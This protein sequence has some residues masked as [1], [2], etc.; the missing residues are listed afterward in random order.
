MG[1]DKKIDGSVEEQKWY[2]GMRP[3]RDI[4]HLL[5]HDGDFL[6]RASDGRT[7][8]VEIILSV[9]SE[10]KGLMHLTLACVEGK[11]QLGLTKSGKKIQRFN[12]IPQL[13]EYYK[14]HKLSNSLILK[15]PVY[16]PDW[17]I[18]H[19]KVTF[20]RTKDHLG[21]GNFCD[22]FK[23]KYDKGDDQVIDVAVKVCH[24]QIEDGK[25]PEE[26]REAREMM[27]GEAKAMSHF[28]HNYIIQLYGVACD[29]PPVLIVMEYCPG[30]SLDK[31]LLEQKENIE[32]AERLV[33]VNEAARG[34]RYL[35]S[36]NCVHR[37]LAARNCLIS[38]QGFIKIS[39][40]GLSK[41]LD[42][43][44]EE[45]TIDESSP[46]I[47]L[48]WMAPESL[49]KP[50]KFSKASD[51][52]SFGVLL[53]EIYNDGEKPWPDW[54]PKKIATFIRKAS[55]PAMP[56]KTPPEVKELVAKMWN[57]NANERPTIREIVAKVW[58]ILR[59]STLPK[60]N[61]FSVNK[62]PGVERVVSLWESSI[63][64][65]NDE[66][67]DTTNKDSI[68]GASTNKFGSGEM[69]R[70]K[71][72]LVEGIMRPM[73]IKKRG[74]RGGL[75]VSGPSTTGVGSI[76]SKLDFS[77]ISSKGKSPVYSG[78]S[79]SASQNAIRPALEEKWK[80]FGETFNLNI[81][82]FMKSVNDSIEQEKFNKMERMIVCVL[83]YFLHIHPEKFKI[84]YRLIGVV[85]D[86]VKKYANR[87]KQNHVHRGFLYILCNSRHFPENILKLFVAITTSLAKQQQILD[88]CYIIAFLHDAIGTNSGL[89]TANRC[90]WIDKPY[91]Q[92]LVELIL[93]P[94]G[95]V[96][97]SNELYASCSL[98]VQEGLTPPEYFP[99]LKPSDN[100]ATDQLL[101]YVEYF[102]TWFENL[103]TEFLPK[104]LFRALSILCGS[105][106][107]RSFV[108]SRIE[109]WINSQKYNREVCEILLV[110][111]KNLDGA[112]D[113]D[114][115]ESLLKLTNKNMKARV[116]ANPLSVA[117]KCAYEK[118]EN[119]TIFV[120]LLLAT[121][122]GPVQNKNSSNL[123][124][125]YSILVAQPDEATAAIAKYCAE[126]LIKDKENTAAKIRSLIK[127]LTRGYMHL[128]GGFFRFS[129]FAKQFLDVISRESLKGIFEHLPMLACETVA[130]ATLASLVAV[131]S[132]NENAFAK[133]FNTTESTISPEAR[134][135]RERFQKEFRE[136][137]VIVLKWLSQGKV[138]FI[139][140]SAHEHAY[141]VLL[142]LG[143]LR[144][145]YTNIDASAVS[146]EGEFKNC[147]RIFGEC[148]ITEEMILLIIGDIDCPLSLPASM[149]VIT[150]LTERASKNWL[151]YSKEPLIRF[152][153]PMKLCMR[154]MEHSIINKKLR[155]LDSKEPV[156][157]NKTYF[158]MGF[159]LIM[160][161]IS[162]GEVPEE[163]E[164]IYEK[165]PMI[166]Y[167][168]QNVLLNTFQFPMPFDGKSQT[169]IY[170]E[171][172]EYNNAE[173]E[174]INGYFERL[175]NQGVFQM[176]G[177]S[178]VY[179]PFLLREP[180]IFGELANFARI[181]N[182][183]S[184][185]ALC[186]KPHLLSIYSEQYGV[187][188][189]IYAI[190]EMIAVNPMGISLVEDEC[191]YLTIEYYLTNGK[192]EEEAQKNTNLE[193]LFG[194]LTNIL[195]KQS[196]SGSD[197]DPVVNTI[198]NSLSSQSYATR[199]AAVTI[200]SRIFPINDG[201]V[202]FDVEQ[203]SKT[204]KFAGNRTHFMKMLALA[205][206][207]ENGP[208]L[209]R[210]YLTFLQDHLEPES[211]HE[212]AR[213]ICGVAFSNRYALRNEICEFFVKYI[214]A[215]PDIRQN[216]QSQ[217]NRTTLEIASQRISVEKD[218]PEAVIH[219]L[220]TYPEQEGADDQYVRSLMEVWLT[221]GSIP[222]R[223]DE[224]TGA[225]EPILNMT[226]RKTMLTSTQKPVVDA[227]L[228]GLTEKDASDFV[229]VS[230]MTIN[231]AEA[232][233]Q[234]ADNMNVDGFDLATLSNMYILLTGY[235][236]KGVKAGTKLLENVKNCLDRL[237][238]SNIV[239]EEEPMVVEEFP[240]DDQPAPFIRADEKSLLLT[241]APPK[242]T[243]QEIASWL[244]TNCAG[245]AQKNRPPPASK[246][247][248]GFIQSVV[249]NSG[250]ATTCLKHIE[251][252]LKFFLANENLFQMLMVVVDAASQRCSDLQNRLE[253][254]AIRVL[255]SVN[256][257]ASVKAVLEKHA[258][259]GIM[260]QKKAASAAKPMISNIGQLANSIRK[261]KDVNERRLLL[262]DF[263]SNVMHEKNEEPKSEDVAIF[264]Q[265]LWDVNSEG[266]DGSDE[267][268][269]H[270]CVSSNWTIHLKRN[271]CVSLLNHY[272]SSL[273][274]LL[275]F[276][277]IESYCRTFPIA[278]YRELFTLK[279]K[280]EKIEFVLNTAAFTSIA[281]YFANIASQSEEFDLNIVS[282]FENMER[283]GGVHASLCLGEQL[284]ATRCANDSKEIRCAAQRII[285]L[286]LDRFPYLTYERG[287][288][289][290]MRILS[291]V[292]T[293]ENCIRK[294]EQI[295]DRIIEAPVENQ[296]IEDI[297]EDDRIATASSSKENDIQNAMIG[298][299]RYGDNRRGPPTK[300]GKW[301]KDES[302]DNGETAAAATKN[303]E[304]ITAI[305]QFNAMLREHPNIVKTKFPIL[306]NFVSNICAMN[307]SD[308]K[309]E[310]RVRK[311]ELVLSAVVTLC[312]YLRDDEFSSVDTALTN[313][314]EF[315]EKHIEE[316]LLHIRDQIAFSELLIKACA[317]YLNR[318]T[319]DARILLRDNKP[320][321]DRICKRCR[322][323]DVDLILDNLVAETV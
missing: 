287:I 24:A 44:K 211:M 76:K 135:V 190:K 176:P 254:L 241:A 84:E 42:G 15:K 6:V 123:N 67:T 167:M 148:G 310:N 16:R 186:R 221:P 87:F 11:W 38:A 52:W 177:P 231:T 263:M 83:K 145:L 306:A 173:N 226:M 28:V 251:A 116:I 245:I 197:A 55:M 73:D 78:S 12:T 273:N 140:S 198:M 312:S 182:P 194:Y 196:T 79:P 311:V 89:G 13:I 137:C 193:F 237:K 65:D 255:K 223:V 117:L 218:V 34:M 37:D 315:Y 259:V 136:Y 204:P 32:I 307:R 26:L 45:E 172:K 22:V 118:P 46:Q 58:K 154:I 149:D 217:S 25:T 228:E 234:R 213:V 29:H 41:L 39:D 220:A 66:H 132:A 151:K 260:S 267:L 184:R 292:E 246:L 50:R 293:R 252:N 225:T 189:V 144:E 269:A 62:L 96:A 156:I 4:E 120:E 216:G 313:C 274:A 99:D 125:L 281:Q 162:G 163:F 98:N 19:D 242:L 166:R 165:F 10:S 262:T 289:W 185:L 205:V 285:D 82:T 261:V 111:C 92:E 169:D 224:Q 129:I 72:K 63:N 286:L 130:H 139:E 152:S 102:K 20:D 105:D 209:A 8:N 272:Q 31:H 301:A 280:N 101:V 240:I 214:D 160:Q 288:A 181:C 88:K 247:P 35:H 43:N 113:R 124:V 69:D 107:V 248:P 201:R 170:Q 75:G 27:L 323:T 142:F 195:G 322:G 178:V 256:P 68:D 59:K 319:T 258:A 74:M 86:L 77:D 305:V 171:V 122:F 210:T 161:W 2:H 94:F 61:K 277:I 271:I 175:T 297:C 47:P 133:K 30:G 244:K 153:D 17:L 199:A 304:T 200:L 188:K 183:L 100:S 131:L 134:Q 110:L 157:A 33:Y 276:R 239:K 284:L 270:K 64:D 295:V 192:D 127:E 202:G 290:S 215:V 187:N 56:A 318:N 219:I 18:K 80:E 235:K 36:R 85:A 141:Y 268:V 53:Y 48:R 109:V 174:I 51:V 250:I 146:S 114:V 121:E 230:R 309:E 296:M 298:S 81:E 112:K 21:S 257:P 95:T 253:T 90:C 321:I 314:F 249:S 238:N 7:N 180:S 5:V 60:P 138:I 23:G 264:L 222:K 227:A 229:L 164:Q 9:R 159:Y 128:R 147:C 233:L 49:K 119:T 232:V 126:E 308:L 150:K 275:I 278:S 236:L 265:T 14:N 155:G 71:P 103:R 212:V 143:R 207:L 108:A 179:D 316:G 1:T 300:K 3:R 203:L 206:D 93:K 303:D 294:C 320:I 317:A 115:I 191:V 299:K 106:Y 279:R 291:N 208:Q 97:P 40:F 302:T 266:S 282:L 54:P 104:P 91:S 158:N 283:E 168:V 243:E 70:K 57:M